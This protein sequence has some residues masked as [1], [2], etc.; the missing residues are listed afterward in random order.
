MSAMSV[1]NPNSLLQNG[2]LVLGAAL[3]VTGLA[4][5]TR[6]LELV[7]RRSDPPLPRTAEQCSDRVAR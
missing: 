3:L 6:R 5:G 2:M 7:D 4:F 1:R